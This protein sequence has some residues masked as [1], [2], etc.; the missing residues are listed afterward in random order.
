MGPG[1]AGNRLEE[2]SGNSGWAAGQWEVARRARERFWGGLDP[3]RPPEVL[4]D[5]AHSKVLMGIKGF[6]SGFVFLALGLS[7]YLCK[8]VSGGPGGSCAPSPGACVLPLG[9][10][11]RCHP[12]FSAQRPP[13][14]AAAAA[15]PRG[16]RPSQGPPTPSP[17]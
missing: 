6:V 3:C 9:P 7:F 14:P 13:E 11:A 15:P 10:P 8:K 2:V 17:R 5:T 16:L 12:L 4:P 1:E